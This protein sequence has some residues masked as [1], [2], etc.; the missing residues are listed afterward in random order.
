[1]KATWYTTLSRLPISIDSPYAKWT[2]KPIQFVQHHKLSWRNLR[3]WKYVFNMIFFISLVLTIFLLTTNGNDHK[4]KLCRQVLNIVIN[5]LIWLAMTQISLTSLYLPILLVW[6]KL[7]IMLTYLVPTATLQPM[8][9]WWVEL[10]TWPR[11]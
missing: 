5:N 3:I 6:H 1:M 8:T 7:R 4:N 10:M 2:Y 11:F 9:Y